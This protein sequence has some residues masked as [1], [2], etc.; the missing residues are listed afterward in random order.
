M[1]FEVLQI[2]LNPPALRLLLEHWVVLWFSSSRCA[3]KPVFVCRIRCWGCL[4]QDRFLL[5]SSQWFSLWQLPVKSQWSIVPSFCVLHSIVCMTPKTPYWLVWMD[6]ITRRETL[7]S[8]GDWCE[9]TLKA[10]ETTLL[11]WHFWAGYSK[12]SKPNY[13]L[14]SFLHKVEMGIPVRVLILWPI[15]DYHTQQIV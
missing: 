7:I 1:Q 11:S 14:R 4:A 10:F 5:F 2:Q 15:T 9:L 12:V 3:W 8:R 13:F 6:T